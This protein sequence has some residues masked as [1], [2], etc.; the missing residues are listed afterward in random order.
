MYALVTCIGYMHD[1]H[2]RSACIVGW[3]ALQ[4]FIRYCMVVKR[5]CAKKVFV[6]MRD[7]SQASIFADKLSD[8]DAKVMQSK[9][10]KAAGKAYLAEIAGCS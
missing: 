9:S 5:A 8:V 6:Q 3:V 10:F 2:A 4:R 1:V 7:C